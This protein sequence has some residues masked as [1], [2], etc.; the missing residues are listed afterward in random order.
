MYLYLEASGLKNDVIFTIEFQHLS[1]RL[2]FVRL[3]YDKRQIGYGEIYPWW[4]PKYG[5]LQ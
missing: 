3:S 2:G 4:S 1:F 5:K